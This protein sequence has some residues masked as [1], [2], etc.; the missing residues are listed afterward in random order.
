M[1]KGCLDCRE[2]GVDRF[3]GVRLTGIGRLCD[4]ILI[5]AQE[6]ELEPER[7]VFFSRN[8]HLGGSAGADDFVVV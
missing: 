4:H 3:I 2:S 8:P 7:N 5:V 1:K 6:E